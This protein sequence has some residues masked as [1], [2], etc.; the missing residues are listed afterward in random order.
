MSEKDKWLEPDEYDE[1]ENCAIC[2]EP[3]GT[4]HKQYFN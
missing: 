1:N 3:L 4:L 2:F